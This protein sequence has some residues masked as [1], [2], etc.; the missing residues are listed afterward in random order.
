MALNIVI[1]ASG[2]SARGYVPSD[3]V[4]VIAVNGAIEWLSR[5]DYWFT[6]D[7]SAV[8]M[9]RM[10]DPRAGVIYCAAVPC[11]TP[12]H[13]RRFKRMSARGKEPRRNTPEWWF[14]RWSCKR[15]LSEKPDEINTG[16]SAYGAL[17][18]AYHLGA[19][20]ITLVG[21]DGTTDDRIEGGKCNN[22][23]HLPML[24]ESAMPQLRARGITVKG[25]PK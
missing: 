18:L 7:S 1:V 3:D 24:F 12:E 10:N 16:N 17:G 6:L 11:A 22:L 9:Q 8:N 14:W 23:S 25:F 21:V 13:V 4:T 2:P 15:G 19:D 20:S 5:A